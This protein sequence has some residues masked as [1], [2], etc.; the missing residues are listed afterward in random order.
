MVTVGCCLAAAVA[1]AE[2]PDYLQGL[3]IREIE[4]GGE[5]AVLLDEATLGITKGT[6]LSRGLLRDAVRRLLE[7]GRWTDV[8]VDVTPHGDGVKLVLRLKPRIVLARISVTGPEEVDEDVTLDALRVGKGSQL[9]DRATA[10]LS[11]RVERAYAERGY[12]GCQV[13][14]QL[15]DTDDPAKKVLLVDVDEGPATRVRNVVFEGESPRDPGPVVS[16]MKVSPGHVLDR[17]ALSEG[18]E[19]A[20][21]YLR[22]HGYYEASLGKPLVRIAE[23]QATI[24]VPS[25]I[26]PHYRLV[27]RGA[28]P[29][30]QSQV[31][32]VLA[33]PERGVSTLTLEGALPDAVVD[34]YVRHGYEAPKVRLQ[35]VRDRRPGHAVLVVDIAPGKQRRVANVTF[36]GARHFE[37]DFLRDQLF[38]YLEE[39]LPDGGLLRQ[40]DSDT[41]SALQRDTAP[42]AARRSA[43]PPGNQARTTYYGPTYDEAIE[44]IRELY[45]ADGYLSARVGPARLTQLDALNVA[46][47]IPVSE[48][49]QTRLY[50]VSVRGTSVVTPRDLLGA[51]G[52][53]RDQPFSYVRLEEA[54]L[55]MLEH[56]HE[57]GYMFAKVEPSVRF[58][59]DRTRAEVEFEVVERFQ[60]KVGEIVVRGAERTNEGF[61]KALLTLDPGDVYTPSEARES[62]DELGSLGVFTS[63]TVRMMDPE[64]PA[65]VKPLLVTVAERR[66]QVLDF[67][68][69]ISTGQGSRAGF[70]YGY[71]N[72][73]GTAI[74]LTLRVQFAYKLL[75]VQDTIQ[76]RYNALTLADR[77]ERRISLGAVIPR[78]PGFGKVRTNLDL[79]H[80]RDNFRDFGLDENAIGMTFTYTGLSPLT[81]ALG[82]DLENNNV[83]LFVD[84]ALDEY[85]AMTTNPQTRAL[86]RVPEGES[87]LV[88]ARTTLSVDKRDNAFVPTRGFFT[89]G[90]AELARTLSATPVMTDEGTTEFMSR[91]IKLS[92]TV[93]GYIPLGKV[94]LAGQFRIGRVFH[95]DPASE[96][97]PNRAFFLG[98][99]DTMRG[100]FQ[101]AMIPQDKADLILA[102][103]NLDP[104]AVVRSG[105]VFMLWR[106]ELRFPIYA[107]LQGGLFTDIG[108]LW[109]DP[110]NV[111]FLRLRPTSGLGLRMSTPVGPIA[112]DY[113]FILL[114]R[115]AL[116][117]PIGSLHF[118]IGLF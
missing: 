37:R 84:E 44:H 107:Q 5:S 4:V 69:G 99:V 56:Y 113:G 28:W 76:E 70:E 72:L 75:F 35:R 11:E 2:I 39:D 13:T 103:P 68:A 108:N 65:T 52:L 110:K 100:Y 15:R 82:G 94:V 101:D 55:R 47:T 116:G 8:Q 41:A 51:S 12:L 95:L 19:R 114:R 36:P 57:R 7:S 111:D 45:G 77:L 80:L 53:I 87:T 27:I 54:R 88:D 48:G 1:R 38:S 67:S 61:I 81:V 93:S 64:L 83:D 104:N 98:G 17:Q 60:V 96:T 102:D 42:A 30:G 105:D 10:E 29:L 97:Y 62:E 34:L 90:T 16:A 73:F 20:Q 22:Q 63:V 79:T 91:F 21:T 49:P 112:L 92:A 26:G 33:L 32:D 18:I 86:L 109:T 58:S 14:V 25:R 117:E 9:D 43:R 115:E 46:A 106:F 118:S 3:P 23:A 89:S 6:A 40:V 59:G 74:G 85:L 78:I 50:A 31:Q 66:N 71:R 24:T